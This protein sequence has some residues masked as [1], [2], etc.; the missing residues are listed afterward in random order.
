MPNHKLP[1]YIFLNHL[2]TKRRLH[3][4]KTQSVPRCKHFYLGYKNQ[5]VVMYG[6]EVVVYSEINTKHIR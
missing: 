2:K 6:A 3:Y 1:K 5:S 4:L